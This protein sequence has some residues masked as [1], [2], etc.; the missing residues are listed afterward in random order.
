MRLVAIQPL[1]H[2]C[3]SLEPGQC[4]IAEGGEAARFIES[5]MAMIEADY[6]KRPWPGSG[7][8]RVQP[9]WS[10]L[11]VAILAGGPSLNIGDVNTACEGADKVIAVNNAVLLASA[12][13]ILYFCDARWFHW[14]P[15][16]VFKFQGRR[17]TLEN[18]HLQRLMEVRCLRDYG[19]AGFAPRSDG[20][21]N[22]R[23]GGYQ[24]LHLAAWLG[25]SRVLLLGFDMRAVDGRLHWHTEHPLPMSPYVFAGWLPCFDALA[26]ELER[27][28]VEVIN[29]TPD[30]ALKA[31]PVMPIEEA[32]CLP[33]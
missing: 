5:G 10:G 20:V 31:F 14:H 12:A 4:F 1:K 13:D 19:A 15:D 7:Y 22:G 26:P 18:L 9:E 17:V 3:G 30:S 11:T 33:A 28:G 25:A 2:A 8:W 29:C 27:H 23:N 24:A 21:T 6:E 32:L 16:L